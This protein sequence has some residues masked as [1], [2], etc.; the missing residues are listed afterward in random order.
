M[1]L[2]SCLLLAAVLMSAAVALAVYMILEAD[3]EP[4]RPL[5]VRNALDM[6]AKAEWDEGLY[7]RVPETKEEENKV[8]F[9]QEIAQARA[10][11]AA[12]DVTMPKTVLGIAR[13][14][15]R[16]IGRKGAL[17]SADDVYMGLEAIGI[18]K[19]KLGN[20]AGAIF[21]GSDWSFWG[22]KRST[23]KSNHGRKIR[24]WKY[25]GF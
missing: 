8:A 14:T 24:T 3:K 15:A 10:T 6:L 5:A 18:P 20:S 1:I 12:E 16:E 4:I 9:N 25:I 7:F 23:R 2:L 21:H 22:M 11:T 13:E 17:V 19:E